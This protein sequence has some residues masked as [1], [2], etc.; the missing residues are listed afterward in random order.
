MSH[1]TTRQ[2]SRRSILKASLASAMT[3]AGAGALSFPSVAHANGFASLNDRVLVNVY[4]GGGPDMRYLFPPAYSANTSTFGHQ[5]WRN[6]SR[7]HAIG[8]SQSAQ[9]QR[10]QDDFFHLSH[11]GTQFGILKRCGWL[12]DMWDQGHVAIVNNAVGASSRNHDHATRVMELGNADAQPEAEG[13]G[14]GGRLGHAA[15][16]NVLALTPVPQRFCFGVDRAAPDNLSR[17]DNDRIIAARNTRRMTL[18]RN[19]PRR[20]EQWYDSRDFVTRAL[21]GYYKLKMQDMQADSPYEQFVDHYEVLSELGERIDERLA[22]VPIPAAFDRLVGSSSTLNEASLGIQIRNLY[23]MFAAND[24]VN[25]RVASLQ[26]GGWDTHDYQAREI[27]PKLAD[28]FGEGQGFATLFEELPEDVKRKAVFVFYG[29]FGRQLKDN[30]A[31]G[32]DHGRGTSVIVLGH[33][34]RG[35]VYGEM[36]PDAE[37]DRLEDESPDIEGQTE[38]DHVF[39][40]LCN[41]VEA[42]AKDAVFPNHASRLSEPGVDFSQLMV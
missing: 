34:V 21:H 4:L 7:A 14:W 42:G 37:L 30:G 1:D 12:K 41:W 22:T 35:G 36:F 3:C 29:E 18:H 5:Y 19:D 25:L 31:G 39:G 17:F 8:G 26:L 23:D 20:S 15:N 38:L 2:I 6:R 10:W 40:A 28:L 9:Q 24:V 13:S 11:N 33:S 32:T 27:E 16:G